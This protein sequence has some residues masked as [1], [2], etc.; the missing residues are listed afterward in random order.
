MGGKL[1]LLNGNS[2]QSS[3]RYKMRHFSRNEELA[4]VNSLPLARKTPKFKGSPAN[5][6]VS[7]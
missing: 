6:G 2:K 1:N 7:E 5:Y 3:K 4:Q